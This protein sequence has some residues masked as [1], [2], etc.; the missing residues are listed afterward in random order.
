MNTCAGPVIRYQDV[1][2]SPWRNGRGRTRE[3]RR[4]DG[5]RLS[6]ATIAAA[7]E[8]SRFPEIDRI[9][10]VARGELELTVGGVT[11]RLTAGQ[12]RSFAGEVPVTATPLAGPVVAVNVMSD[13]G[14]GRADVSVARICGAVPPAAAM[15]VLTGSVIV[16]DGSRLGPLDTLSPVAAGSA[17][18]ED[19]LVVLI[20]GVDTDQR[21]ARG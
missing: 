16:P 1:P 11:D 13:R 14:R 21:G 7:G 17:R 5:W 19:A 18:A 2:D 12:V 9:F 10:V 6:I 3:I 4:G 15:V 20:T 8:F